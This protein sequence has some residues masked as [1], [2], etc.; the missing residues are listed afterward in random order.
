MRNRIGFFLLF[1]CLMAAHAAADMPKSI[2]VLGTTL[3]LKNEKK[4]ADLYLAEYIPE[5]EQFENF[6]KMLAVWG[7]LDGS[8]A[9]FQVKAKIQFV[10]D[11]KAKDPFANFS[12][13]QSNDKKTYG[14]D[15][16][17]SEGNV[18]EHNVWTFQ[19]V[20]GGVLAYQYAR[21][22]Y[23]GKSSGPVEAFLKGIPAIRDQVMGFF[24]TA[25]LPQPDG[26]SSK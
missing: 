6:T 16:L 5:G 11:R 19:N 2:A 1:M 23:E 25:S 7:R 3:V 10:K 8:T 24:K 17:I 22:H 26:Y 12:A 20:K 14:L 15:F 21:R 13:F 9:E 18:M 4:S